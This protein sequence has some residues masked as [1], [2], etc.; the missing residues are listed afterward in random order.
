MG[1]IDFD[2]GALAV[3]SYSNVIHARSLG[4]GQTGIG[5]IDG[6]VGT[7]REETVYTVAPAEV[8][9]GARADAH[10]IQRR[11]R[12]MKGTNVL[13]ALSVELPGGTLTWE[14]PYGRYGL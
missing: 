2:N 5:Q 10:P 3:M 6:T 7:I 4:R 1:V 8:E 11:M 14:N 13:E 9:S 12:E